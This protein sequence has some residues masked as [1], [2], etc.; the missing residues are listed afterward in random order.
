[1][2]QGLGDVQKPSNTH[3]IRIGAPLSR[4]MD[5]IAQDYFSSAVGLTLYLQGSKSPYL[6]RGFDILRDLM[7]RSKG[8]MLAAN[9]GIAL[10]HGTAKPFFRVEAKGSKQDALIQSAQSD[11][12]SALELTEDALATLRQDKDK[13]LNL[14]Y[15]RV[16]RR[17]AEYHKALGDDRPARQELMRLAK[18]LPARGANAN[19]V[20]SYEALASS[21]PGP[22]SPSKSRPAS[23]GTS[24]R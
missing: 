15:G 17:R 9:I 19:V 21:E 16:V 7:E 1:V 24:R 13:A 4:E 12:K 10:A 20:R 11:P 5:R 8:T 23:R 6:R 22:K 18:E 3:S 2:Y 14:A